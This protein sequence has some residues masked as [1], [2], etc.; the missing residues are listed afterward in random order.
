MHERIVQVDG[1]LAKEQ[2]EVSHRDR[3]HRAR[4][5]HLEGV[6]GPKAALPQAPEKRPGKDEHQQQVRDGQCQ[7]EHGLQGW[8]VR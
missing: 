7:M 2:R 5:D 8:F 6:V 4:Q 1:H 3:R